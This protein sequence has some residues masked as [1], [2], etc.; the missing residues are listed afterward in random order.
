MIGLGF[1]KNTIETELPLR[2]LLAF[3]NNSSWRHNTAFLSHVCYSHIAV[4]LNFSL[5]ARCIFVISVS[6]TRQKFQ[7]RNLES[8]QSIQDLSSNLISMLTRKAVSP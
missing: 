6:A 3:E 1:D 5:I 7:A 4:R 8:W 2:D